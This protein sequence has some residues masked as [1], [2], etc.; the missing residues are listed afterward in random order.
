[1]RSR[2]RATRPASRSR[3]LIAFATVALAGP[4][5]AQSTGPARSDAAAA[6][7]AAPSAAL[8]KLPATRRLRDAMVDSGDFRAALSPA[9]EAV[10]VQA[11]ARDAGY[12]GD[13][14]VLAR[15]EAE[16]GEFDKAE[17]NYLRAIDALQAAGGEYAL[18]LVG[19]YRG[20]GRSYIKARRYPDAIIALETARSISQRN[21]GLF[22]VEQAPLLDDITT[23]YLGLG[24]TREAQRVQ[25]ERLDNAVK[26]FGANDQR[27]IPYRYQ[28]A[29]YYQRS[30]L[31]ESAREQ[32][33]EV[34]KTQES[35]LGAG[36]PGLLDPLRQL[37]RIDLLTSQTQAREAHARL[38]SVLEQNPNSEPV[39]RGLALATLGDWAIVANDSDAAR[40][41]YKQA[42]QAL[43]SQPDFDVAAAFA[44]PEMIDFIAPLS[45][46]DRGEKSKP[47]AWAEIDFDFDVTADGRPLNVR[48]VHRDGAAPSPLESRYS[49]R[50]RETHFRPRI[51]AGE[52]VATDNVQ[53][54]HYF[55]FYVDAKKKPGA[56]EAGDGG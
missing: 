32:Y 37:V 19:P 5:A 8:A 43:R 28:L 56:E 1:M 46:V 40:D 26:R 14:T 53:L 50:L 42:W 2:T 23:A 13:L 34:L 12:T 38:V 3:W 6:S 9:L 48:V 44:R 22:N 35:L 24:D 15:I 41:F 7:P 18:E 20:L 25:L 17:A 4:L 30:R 29:D 11:D 49:R 39:E 16:L 52:P 45:S 51:V 33:A 27:V 36:H 47:Y 21:L 54:T 55:R 31:P 10:A